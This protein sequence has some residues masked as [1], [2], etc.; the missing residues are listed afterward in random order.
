[1]RMNWWGDRARRVCLAV[2]G[3]ALAA[4]PGGCAYKMIETPYVSYREAGRA[5]YANVPEGL[6]TPEIPVIYVT[7][8]E[9]SGSDER[10]PVYTYGRSPRM[11]YGIAHISPGKGVTWEQL[12]EDSVSARR[13]RTYSPKVVKVE[14]LGTIEPT[15]KLLEA[16]EGRLA[17]RPGA[18]EEMDAEREQF[19]RVLSRYLDHSDRKEVVVFV[20]GYN[21]T[22]DDAVLRIAEAWHLSGRQGVPIVYSW[23]AGSGGLK[24]Y[25]YDRESGEFTI[26]HLKML[27]MMLARCPQVEKVHLVSHSRGT[28]VATTALRELHA[29]CRGALEI[30]PVSQAL[31]LT[32]VEI[33]GGPRSTREIL[34]LATLVL[35]APDLDS[36][37]FV[38]RFFG[39]NLLAAADRTIIYFSE[40][41]SAL[42]LA[43]WLFR[44]RRRLGAMR[45]DDFTPEARALALQ[46]GQL[47]FINCRVRG[48][49]SHSYILQHPA[50]L[51]D[52]ILALRDGRTPGAEHGR[53]LTQPFPG[54][55]EMEPDYLKP[56][57]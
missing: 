34:K 39:E 26:V 4:A 49:D 9:S 13:S 16:S 56:K 12:V 47:Q 42:G 3:V 57:N 11:A 20:H 22:F 37:V 53:P 23:P 50:A 32:P 14:E 21:N 40:E 48:Y 46:L 31:G 17:V 7:D 8:R 51:S 6:R 55:W 24:G 44:S 28:D 25:A 41:D 18:A 36:Q 5:I 10:G 1:M 33:Q 19:Y 45:L 29:E 43:D 35:A 38:Q 15:T 30:G 52:I 54:M 27:L 2:I